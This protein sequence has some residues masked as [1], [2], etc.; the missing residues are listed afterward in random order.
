VLVDAGRARQDDGGKELLQ[1]DVLFS[2]QQLF[3]AFSFLEAEIVLQAQRDGP[4]QRQLERVVGGRVEG[5]AAVKGIAG[6]TGILPLRAYRGR[7]QGQAQHGKKHRPARLPGTRL[8]R[9][10]HF[11]HSLR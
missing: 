10:I 3:A 1:R 9:W 4:V 8:L 11:H 2:L 6:G 7:G 5:D